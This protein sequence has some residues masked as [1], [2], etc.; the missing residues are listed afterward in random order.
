MIKE[1][2]PQD[3]IKQLSDY[4]HSPNDGSSEFVIT[5]TS[6]VHLEAAIA[7][8]MASAGKIQ[9]VCTENDTSII[10]SWHQEKDLIKLPFPLDAIG[11]IDFAKNWLRQLDK[12]KLPPE[13]DHDGSNSH[14]WR[15]NKIGYWNTFKVSFKWIEHHK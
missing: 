11:V 7:M 6:T 4:V 13:P 3:I 8:L 12:S 14:G 1:N 10:F 15:I 5:G 9:Y 2:L